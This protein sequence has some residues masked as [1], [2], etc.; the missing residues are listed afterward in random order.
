MT[1]TVA[2]IP[3]KSEPG[4]N[5]NEVVVYIP[6]IFRTGASPSNG[7]A[8][9]PRLSLGEESYSSAKVQ[10]AYS[11]ITIDIAVFHGLNKKTSQEKPIIHNILCSKTFCKFVDFLFLTH[12]QHT[13]GIGKNMNITRICLTFYKAKIILVLHIKI[14]FFCLEGFNADFDVYCYLMTFRDFKWPQNSTFISEPKVKSISMLKSWSLGHLV[15]TFEHT[16][17]EN[18]RYT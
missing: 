15:M 13:A 2:V 11:T 18:T 5:G 16:H 4:Y 14:R 3:V 9:Y 12:I 6:Q 17:D 7:L 8:L 10:S 1:R